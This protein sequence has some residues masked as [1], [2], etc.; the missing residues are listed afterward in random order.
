MK[1]YLNK[2]DVVRVKSGGPLMVSE[3]AGEV[4]HYE[5]GRG[6]RDEDQLVKCYWHDG[7]RLKF[8]EFPLFTI[9]KVDKTT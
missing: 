7:E 5:Y 2:G 8:A 3:K 9:M 6:E 1:I 4:N